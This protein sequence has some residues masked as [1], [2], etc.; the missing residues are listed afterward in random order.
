VIARAAAIA[1]LLLAGGCA[2]VAPP[3][4]AGGWP[5][6]RAALQSL[7]DWALDGRI[8]VAAGEDGFSGG[9][10][11]VQAGER[12]DIVLSG[13]M[14]GDAMTIRVDGAR[15]AVTVRGEE[16]A[17]ADGEALFAR[18][19]GGER[20]LPIAQMRYWLVG[21]PAPGSPHEETLGADQRL[22][23]LAQSGWKVR[24]DRYEAVGA[25]ALPARMELTSA[26]LRLR[27][28]VSRWQVLP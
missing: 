6:R 23:A 17:E 24:Y 7:D 11:W 5:E 12:A 3:A 22:A 28:A 15:A 27:V 9:V 18:H 19:F 8:A 25:L 16:L 14:G 13:P 10:D 2:T 26:G 4:P 21:V 20:S 1:L